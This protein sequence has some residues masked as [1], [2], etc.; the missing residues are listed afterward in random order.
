MALLVRT[1]DKHRN[2]FKEEAA[3]FLRQDDVPADPLV[4]LRTKENRLSVYLVE[5][6]KS[7]VERIVRAI[8][9]GKQKIEHQSYIV[10][11]SKVL[12][13]AGIEME[14]NAGDT[15]DA[16]INHLHRDLVLTGKKLALL[17]QGM[18]QDGEE[19]ATILREH[20]RELVEQGIHAGELPEEY[21]EKLK[22]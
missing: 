7:N 13:K 12:E 8:A 14:E 19:V 1:V 3:P 22:K 10:F 21:R 16:G 4:D 17:A 15:K 11:D 2:W 5:Q 6:D 9:S 20:L 18:L